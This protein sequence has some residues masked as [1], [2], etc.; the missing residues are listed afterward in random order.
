ML[1]RT[2]NTLA[3]KAPTSIVARVANRQINL[4]WTASNLNGGSAV[5]DYIVEFRPS[6]GG[7]WQVFNDGVR[8]ATTADVTGLTNDTR[9]DFRVKAENST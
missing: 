1:V 8:T 4:S 3:P 7:Q 9:Y 6:N 2:L 5:K